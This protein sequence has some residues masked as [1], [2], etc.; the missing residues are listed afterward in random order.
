MTTVNRP[1]KAT[2]AALLTLAIVVLFFSPAGAAI[3]Q[4]VGGQ[5]IWPVPQLFVHVFHWIFA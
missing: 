3:V 1:A 4:F 2:A 5:L